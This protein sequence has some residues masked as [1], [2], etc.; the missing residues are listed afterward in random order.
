M[1]TPKAVPQFEFKS[2]E[3]FI[4]ENNNFYASMILDGNRS[5]ENEQFY[6]RFSKVAPKLAE[7]LKQSMTMENRG[8][9]MALPWEKVFPW[10]KLWEAYKIMSSLVYIGDLYVKGE[11]DYCFLTR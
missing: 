10:D 1:E 5:R 3:H 6:Q 8:K 4:E 7:E 9:G 2:L 11:N